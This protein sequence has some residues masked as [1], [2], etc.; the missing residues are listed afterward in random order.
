MVGEGVGDGDEGDKKA[1]AW[2]GGREGEGER[3]REEG[4]GGIGRR[5]DGLRAGEG[6]KAATGREVKTR[7]ESLSRGRIIRWPATPPP[8]N[9][10][11]FGPVPATLQSASTLLSLARSLSAHHATLATRRLAPFPAL[12]YPVPR[13]SLSSQVIARPA[14][15]VT[16]LSPSQPTVHQSSHT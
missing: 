14:A 12:R 9:H 10:I 13:S 8:S 16:D 4:T 11:H 2:R 5:V 15:T 6:A 3:E 7:P 1:D